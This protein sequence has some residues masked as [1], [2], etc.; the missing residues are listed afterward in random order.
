M[1]ERKVFL[2][3]GLFEKHFM[4]SKITTRT[5]TTKEKILGH[6]VG[7]LGLIL[8]V[9]TIA[10]LV[11]KFFTQQC[12]AMYG[13]GNLDAISNMGVAYEWVM[14]SAKIIAIFL[15]LLIGWLVQRTQSK[16]GRF[17]PWHLIF[18]FVTIIIGCLIFLFPGNDWGIPYWVYFFFLVIC[19][20]TVGVSFFY[21]FRDNI[22]SVSTRNS[23]EKAL[24]KFIRQLCWTLISGILIGML[25]SMVALPYWLEKDI[26][27][28]PILIICCSIVAI[29][30]LLLEY[31]Y[32]KERI[33]EDV[34]KEVGEGKENNIPLKQQLKALLTNKYFV[35]MMVLT[36]ITGVMDNFKGG[37]VQYFYIKFLL[38]GENDPLMFTIYQVITGI[39][40]GIGIF[41]M[42]PLAKKFGIRNVSWCGYALVF[43]FSIIGLIFPSNLPIVMV[44][45]FFK[46]VGMLPNAYVMGTL[47][48]YA[49]DDVEFRSHVRLEGLMGVSIILAVQNAIYAP[50]AGGYESQLLQ[51]G[52]VDAPGVSVNDE[53]RNFMSMSFYLF[54]IIVAAAYL[55]LLPF[56]NV[57]KK[58]P[59]INEEL[60]KREKEA[61]E[62]RGEV[63]VSPD[64]KIK[65]EEAQR[66]KEYEENRIADLK[67]KCLK[68]GLDFETENKKYLEKK[69]E[70]ERKAKEKEEKK[71]IKK[72]K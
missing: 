72:E 6:L 53:I 12:G 52:F 66:E 25:I 2:S 42:W 20:N 46:Q 33:V 67:E 45:G 38:N 71:R 21:V 44:S 23:K 62:A 13:T 41:A 31:F 47:L 34:G 24:L 9:N 70:K 29:P 27:G 32:T 51:L 4:D 18:G 10:A 59:M 55:I 35:I 28:Y 19:Y 40:L 16:Q 48:Y 7:P 11:E 54:D 30:L 8:V 58:L 68:K 17:R 60:I 5:I 15:G 39:P 1:K 43:I 3:H 26:S 50:F 56:V 65:L 63:W 37:N 69:A 57:E 22:V 14:T 61:C 64:E 36:T 49:Y